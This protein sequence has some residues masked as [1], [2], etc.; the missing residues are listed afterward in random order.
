MMRIKV[1]NNGSLLFVLKRSI[2]DNALWYNLGRDGAVTA[3][4]HMANGDIESL[5]ALDRLAYKPTMLSQTVF[6]LPHTD[7]EFDVSN[8]Y[9]T[10]CNCKH[11]DHRAR[12]TGVYINAKMT[13]TGYKVHEIR[14]RTHSN[15][16][17]GNVTSK[18]V[19]VIT[20]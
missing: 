3:T 14:I 10:I 7:F 5:T 4:W 15:D 11:V 20:K 1:D 2:N 12:V 9:A 17:I 6:K 16:T 19:S 18:W 8:G 13:L